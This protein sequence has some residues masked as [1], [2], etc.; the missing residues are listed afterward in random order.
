MV[1]LQQFNKWHHYN[2][3]EL[4]DEPGR[5]TELF[6]HARLHDR[7]PMSYKHLRAGK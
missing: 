2:I 3:K 7:S 5:H 1:Y 6:H 4:I